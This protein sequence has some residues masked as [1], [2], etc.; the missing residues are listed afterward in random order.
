MTGTGH[1]TVQVRAVFANDFKSAYTPTRDVV[2]TIAEPGGHEDPAH[3][4]AGQAR[5]DVRVEH[6]D[7]RQAV[8]GAGLADSGLRR[9]RS[10]TS[11]PTRRATRRCSPSRTSSTAACMYWR[12]AV[13]DPDGNVGRV[14]EGQEVHDPRTHA[15]ADH[16]RA[17]ARAPPGVA[18]VT[19]LNAEGQADQ[20]RRGASSRAPA[21]RRSRR[22][23]TRRA[24]ST[25]RSSPQRAGNLAAH[26][27]QEAV[28]GRL[29]GR[30]GRVRPCR[31]AGPSPGTPA[32]AAPPQWRP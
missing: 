31:G 15:G 12:V 21:S 32:C 6:E 27:D 25:S 3:Q 28:Q 30:S 1:G 18:T 20:G 24:S 2:H 26:G 14:L 7:Q 11:P 23:R 5:A 10:S 22:R 4:Q 19:V 29:H 13:I 17:G 8:Q 9:V 16:G